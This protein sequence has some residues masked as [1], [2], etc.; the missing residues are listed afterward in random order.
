M[1]F[2]DDS[3]V[4]KAANGVT[5]ALTRHV[6]PL[7]LWADALG[8]I[9]GIG[10]FLVVKRHLPTGGAAQPSAAP[11]VPGA[12][13]G[14]G[15]G[16]EANTQPPALDNPPA[17]PA[18][19]SNTDAFTQAFSNVTAQI[20]TLAQQVAGIAQ[21]SPA[22]PAAVASPPV[23]VPPIVSISGSGLNPQASPSKPTTVTYNGEQ[24]TPEQAGANII[25]AAP[26]GQQSSYA[27]Y[28][29][30]HGIAY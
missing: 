17:A 15:S 8:L 20:A 13:S 29:Q 5:G 19:Q 30:E 10:L 22:V 4:G 9:G 26:A 18:P 3:P 23:T 1:P 25:A 14:G 7:P 27:T 16:T 2:D 12:P 24:V 11:P 28:F 6:G 21:R